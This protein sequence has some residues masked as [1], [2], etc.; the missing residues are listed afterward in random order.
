[1]NANVTASLLSFTKL[2]INGDISSDGTML[3]LAKGAVTFGAG[4]ATDRTYA[5]SLHGAVTLSGA[6]LSMGA[7]TEIDAGGVITI[8]TVGDATLGQLNSTASY[9]AAGNA[10]SIVVSAGGVSTGAILSNGDGR[11][12]LVASGTD[13]H[14]ALSASSIG[15]SSQRVTFNAPFLS[16]TA[17]TGDIYLSALAS[18]EASLLSAVKGS[19]DMRGSGNLTLDSVVAGTDTGASGTFN[20]ATSA[21]SITIGTAASSGSQTVHASQNVAFKVLA[22]HRRCRRRR[23]RYQRHGRQRLHPGADG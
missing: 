16:A 15:T 19:V 12:N 14:I 4:T 8:A 11:T 5:A 23:R 7:Y 9:A 10:A 22:G 2:N 13:A 17:S 21:G 20:A 1:M 18:V 3:L 6:S